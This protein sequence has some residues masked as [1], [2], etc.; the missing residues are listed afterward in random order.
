MFARRWEG[1]QRQ[2]A[3]AYHAGRKPRP[4]NEPGAGQCLQQHASIA[5]GERLLQADQIGVGVPDQG[6]DRPRAFGA[7][8]REE[9]SAGKFAPSLI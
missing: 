7:F 5:A 4:V 1:R 8:G 2:Q 6:P 3:V 9:I